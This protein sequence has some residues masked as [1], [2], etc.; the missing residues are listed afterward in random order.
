MR[1]VLCVVLGLVTVA[2]QAVAPIVGGP[3]EGCDAV[4]DLRGPAALRTGRLA[5]EGAAGQP[6]LLTGVVRGRDRQP[7]GGVIVYGYQTNAA[8][9]YE[10]DD[11]A[12]SRAGRRHGRYRGWVRT[13]GE[14]RFELRTVRPGGYPNSDIPEHI[15][16][17]VLEPGCAT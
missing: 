16:L 9:L 2:A 5:P 14:G 13:D 17:H 8:G 3:C 12:P 1:G 7:V 11:R 10:P 15:H 6:M 4:F